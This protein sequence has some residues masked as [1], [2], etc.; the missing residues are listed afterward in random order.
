MPRLHH[1]GTT[2]TD[3][4][5]AVAFYRRVFGFDLLD[6]FTVSGEEFATA[7]DVPDATARFAHLDGG[8]GVRVEL[9]E[10]DPE[11]E[12]AAAERVNQPGAKHL[13][14]AVDD[15]DAF[16]EG[17]PDDVETVSGPRTTESGATICFLR[18]P[19]GNLVEVIEA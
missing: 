17:L 5:T 13:A 18:D 15:A 14:V 19:D 9:V 4:D 12:G 3:L 11:G 16:H 6:E 8:G 7:V 2:V 1:T 10:Y